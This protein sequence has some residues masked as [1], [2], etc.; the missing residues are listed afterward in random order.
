MN[1]LQNTDLPVMVDFARP[2]TW[3]ALRDRLRDAT[4]RYGSGWYQIVHFDLHGA[5]GDYTWLAH[6]GDHERPVPV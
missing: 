5:F 2:G 6:P 3:A 1:A 4:D